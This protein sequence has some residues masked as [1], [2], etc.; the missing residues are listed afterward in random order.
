M[1]DRSERTFI[2]VKPDGVQ[3][4]LIGE[5]IKRF[6][7]KGYK[8]V[9]LKFMQVALPQTYFIVHIFHC[10]RLLQPTLELLQEHYAE[11]KALPFYDGLCKFM[12]SGPVAAMVRCEQKDTLSCHALIGCRCGRV[13]MW[14]QLDEKCWERLIL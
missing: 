5:I 2:M 14:W 13:C 6:E 1:G 8:L 11:L 10:P 7:Q 9:A 3:R 4:G 12:S